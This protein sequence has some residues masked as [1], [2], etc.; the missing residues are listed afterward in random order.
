MALLQS[1]ADPRR[2]LLNA[3]RALRGAAGAAP[4]VFVLTD[5]E[6]LADAGRLVSRLPPGWG[7]IYRHFGAADRLREGRRL[8]LLC[9]RAHR[10]FL[11]SDDWGLA[12]RLP[13]SGIHFPEK[14]LRALA[15]RRR[16]RG[17]L[18]SASA[19]SWRGVVQA[20]RAGADLVFL[21]PVFATRSAGAGRPIGP[22]GLRSIALR[23]TIPVYALGGVNA[24]TAG[25]LGPFYRKGIAG[26]GLVDAA[27]PGGRPDT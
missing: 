27:W 14:R 25:R 5:P 12:R 9:R 17:W 24:L 22:Y 10:T 8:A 2:K 13:C 21:S 4:A 26:F 16:R 20:R 3:E 19:H 6:R 15:G 23:T 18:F 7:L 11:V 1:H